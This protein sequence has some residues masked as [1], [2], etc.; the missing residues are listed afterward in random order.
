MAGTEAEHG[1]IGRHVVMVPVTQLPFFL[2][3]ILAF[4]FLFIFASTL[5][6]I[7]ILSFYYRVFPQHRG[8]EIASLTLGVIALAFFVTSVCFHT[9]NFPVKKW[10]LMNFLSVYHTHGVLHSS[11]WILGQDCT[12]AVHKTRGR[13]DFPF[14]YKSHSGRCDALDSYTANMES[15]SQAGKEALD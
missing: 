9:T 7:S 5:G 13:Y 14:G 6:R 3:T 4:D 8:T 11:S 1:V 12:S 10:V 15:T 2:K